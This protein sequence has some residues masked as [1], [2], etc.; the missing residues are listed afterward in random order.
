V[1]LVSK[2]T[3]AASSRSFFRCALLSV[4]LRGAAVWRG[5]GAAGKEVS[6]GVAVAVVGIGL[7]SCVDMGFAPLSENGLKIKRGSLF[8]YRSNPTL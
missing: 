8:K 2:P 6:T 5:A 4:A 3:I 7:V 1:V